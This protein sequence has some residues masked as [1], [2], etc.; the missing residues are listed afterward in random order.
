MHIKL[1]LNVCIHRIF[2][3]YYEDED[4]PLYERRY[5]IEEVIGDIAYFDGSVYSLVSYC[6]NEGQYD[7]EIKC[8]KSNY[9]EIA[10]LV[11]P[12]TFNLL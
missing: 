12:V 11:S 9:S 1:H 3:E 2:P 5:D 7:M 4:S 6:F 10:K 8:P